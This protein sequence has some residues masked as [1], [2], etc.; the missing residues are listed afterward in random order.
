[1]QHTNLQYFI[2]LLEVFR[3]CLINN[4]LDKQ[5]IIAWADERIEQENE[6]A[7]FLIELSLC[8][9]KNINDMISLLH[10]Y[11]GENKPQ[12]TGRVVLGYIYREY[13]AQRLSLQQVVTTI[14]WLD[15]H[16]D[17]SKEEHHFLQS[18]DLE[19]DLALDG[20]GSIAEAEKQALHLT[21]CY[22]DF[23]LKNTQHWEKINTSVLEKVKAIYQNSKP[24]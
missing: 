10:N 17:L 9:R 11:A 24:W 1:M 12:L 8:T 7:Y 18:I 14:N 4:L 5:H 20:Y 22:Q 2:G 15:L 16:C 3:I 21:S 13:T 6:P 19:Y 23:D